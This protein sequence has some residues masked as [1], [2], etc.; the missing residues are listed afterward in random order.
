MADVFDKAKRSEIMSHIKGIDTEPEMIVRRFLHGSGIRYGLHNK[1][2]TGKPDLKLNKYNILIFVNGCFWHGHSCKAMPKTNRKF[3]RDKILKN[4][5]R[6]KVTKTKLKKQ[7]WEVIE[8]WQC[9]L[10]PKKRERSLNRLLN[11]IL[12]V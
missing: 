4:I 12:T 10:R 11:K 7:G 2:L 9:E 8:V 6:D 5:D 1:N 3:W